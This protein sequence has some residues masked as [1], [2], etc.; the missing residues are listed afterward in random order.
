SIGFILLGISVFNQSGL[1]GSVYYLVHDMLIKAVL[2]LL[3][4]V[5]VY[6]AGTSNLTKMGGLIHSYPG[7]A[8]LL[9]ISAFVLA[10]IPPFSGFIGK[11]LLLKGAFENG[12]IAIVII[13]LLTSL[14]ILYSVMKIF[15]QGF[16]GEK[17]ENIV[18]KPIN[19][20]VFPIV[21]L[22]IF[23]IFLGVGAEMV[24]PSIESISQYLLD[25]E[26][27]INSVLKE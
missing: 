2:F 1:G 20:F 9:F 8:W 26:V 27:Y 6:V 4:G 21:F 14:L 17:N 11:L 10:G 25:P 23:S 3:I 5:V 15:I 19:G 24:Y 22:L 16:W 18:K 7:L 12:N 13:G